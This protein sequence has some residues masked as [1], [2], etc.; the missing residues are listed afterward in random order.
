MIKE[1]LEEGELNEMILPRKDNDKALKG[2]VKSL[3][4]HI[5]TLEKTLK[6]LEKGNFSDNQANRMRGD[7]NANSQNLNN[8]MSNLDYMIY[9]GVRD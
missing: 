4:N 6:F 7:Y 2:V 1:I 5:K 8:A 3:K 9:K